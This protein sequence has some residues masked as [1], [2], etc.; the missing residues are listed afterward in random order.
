MKEE[1]EELFADVI[2]DYSEIRNRL[3]IDLVPKN[4]DLTNVPH[5]TM[6]DLNYVCK[7]IV[8]NVVVLIDNT[9]LDRY[10]ITEAQ[11]FHDAFEN[12]Q[13]T[14]PAV[15]TGMSEALS[16]DPIDDDDEILFVAT[17]PD[18]VHGA[19]VIAYPGFFDK[20]AKR[21]GGDFF[22]LPSSIHEVILVKDNGN[23]DAGGLSA[24]V[25]GVNSTEVSPEEQLS[26][27]AYHYDS[28]EHVFELAEQFK[29]R[30]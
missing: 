16:L 8:E 22:V 14:R 13:R 23:L 1:K 27:N 5:G 26:D 7:A 24:V 4:Q 17:T 6:A 30:K 19:G 25:R 29:A 10:G 3:I 20:A 18:G 9:L 15:I 12:A 11:L 2:A 28:R 21:L